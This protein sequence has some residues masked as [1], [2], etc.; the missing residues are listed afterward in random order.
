MNEELLEEAKARV[1]D[2]L[3]QTQAQTEDAAQ[4]LGGL[5]R[6]GF[7]KLKQASDK[8]ADAIRRDISSRP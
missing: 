3:R 2:A 4:Q 1:Q 7:E 8:A 5:L 6:I